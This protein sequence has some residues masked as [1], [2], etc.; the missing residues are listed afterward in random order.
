[1]VP[2]QDKK[3]DRLHPDGPSPDSLTE[4]VNRH[5]PEKKITVLI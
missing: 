3:Q 5:E 1:M 4:K 2:I